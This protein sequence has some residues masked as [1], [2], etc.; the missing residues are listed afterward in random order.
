MNV[1]LESSSSDPALQVANLWKVFP[2]KRRR[3]GSGSGVGAV[4]GLEYSGG[5]TCPLGRNC[6]G[7]STFLNMF[8]A[9]LKPTTGLIKLFKLV[10]RFHV[11]EEDLVMKYEGI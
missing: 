7:K 4:R 5:I 1:G 8:V 6:A 9:L 2:S 10:R 11:R 3:C